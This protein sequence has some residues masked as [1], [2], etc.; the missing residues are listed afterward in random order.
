[1][2]VRLS[3]RVIDDA[4]Y[5]G[6]GGCYLWDTDIRGFGLRIYP[7][8]RKSFV[9]TYHHRGKQRFYTLG[10]FGVL[11]LHEARTEALE[12]LAL[13]RKGEDPSGQR[14]AERRSPTMTDLAD[15]HINEHATINNKPRSVKRARQLWDRCV[16]PRLGKRRVSDI[17]RSDIA[18][19]ITDMSDTKAMANKVISLLSKAFNLAE[20]WGWRPE[21]TN[22]CRHIKRYKEESRERY[23]SAS[24]LQRLGETLVALEQEG[25]VLPQVIAAIRLLVLTGCRSAEILGLRWEE[26][27]FERKCLELKDSKTGKRKVMLNTAA[28]QVL[29]GLDRFVDNPHVIPGGKPGQHLS[30]LQPVWNRVRVEA[31]IADVRVHDLRHT[32]ASIGVNSGQSLAVVGKLLGHTKIL[33][34]QRY[35]HL[36]DDP[37]RKANEQI[38]STLAA[39]LTAQPKAEVREIRPAG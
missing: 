13:A 21:G 2:K 7:S 36:A 1:M 31:D 38:G 24:E 3:K 39:N 18:Q 33:T 27:D 6:K 28:L 16:L 5:Q 11:T 23:L 14:I 8:G 15:R 12:T 29:D 30:S 9:V 25:K 17:R 26:V 22:P 35:A 10:L 34:T 19:L 20:V 32:F 4:R 37:L